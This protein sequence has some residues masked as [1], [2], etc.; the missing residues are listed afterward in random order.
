LQGRDLAAAVCEPRRMIRS[1]SFSTKANTLEFSSAQ[2][3][4]T[5]ESASYAG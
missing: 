1:M 2:R 4:K 5:R 3:S